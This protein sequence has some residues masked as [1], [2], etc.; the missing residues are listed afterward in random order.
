MEEQVYYS[1]I[2]ER[3][4]RMAEE[5]QVVTDLELKNTKSKRK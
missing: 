1:P 3:M 2:Q 5:V 4:K